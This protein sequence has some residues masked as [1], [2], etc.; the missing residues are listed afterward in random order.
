LP[1]VPSASELG[2]D[3]L[4]TENWTGFLVPTGT[5][6]A[7][8]MKLHDAITRVGASPS[9]V[10]AVRKAGSVAATSTSPEEI[11]AIMK[12]DIEHWR[13]IIKAYSIKVE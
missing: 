2:L 7:I 11:Q 3:D 1:G 13:R 10:E 8:V 6:R 12:A 9:V 5:D 4:L